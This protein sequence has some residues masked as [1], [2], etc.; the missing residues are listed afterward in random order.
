MPVIMLKILGINIQNLEA[1][2]LFTPL[3]HTAC[4]TQ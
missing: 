3:N 2:D 1:L 4:A